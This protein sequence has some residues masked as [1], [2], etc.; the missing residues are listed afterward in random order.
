VIRPIQYLRGIAALMVVWHHCLHQLPGLYDLFPLDFTATG[1]DIF[2]VIS[3]FIM[4]VT[5]SGK[6]IS[7]REFFAHRVV[8]VVPL[9]WAATTLM[10]AL[11][12]LIP[13]Q[14]N[15]AQ[16]TA[17]TFVESLMFIPYDSPSF[18]GNPYPMLVPGWT[19]NYEMFFYAMFAASLAVPARSRL[20]GIALLFCQLAAIGHMFGP[21]VGAKFVYTDS[22]LLEFVAGM[23]I[24]TLWVKGK[25][26]EW[27]A[28]FGIAAIVGGFY[29]LMVGNSQMTLL[30]GASLIVLG[31]LTHSIRKI[32]LWPMMELGNASYSI[33]LT[34]LFTLGAM[35]D[36]W[37]HLPPSTVSSYAFMGVSLA[38][39][40]VAGWACYWMVERPMTARL[41][42]VVK[43]RIRREVAASS[44]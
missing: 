11:Y 31:S 25:V 37:K 6:D 43:R 4:V 41:Q 5:T 39:C 18:P 38:A 27:P 42:G 12:L 34:H 23:V 33:Y 24:G 19:L 28:A 2:F 8:R 44:A 13:S 10:A 17:R 30:A 36:V 3:G 40:A 22:R 1:V 14:F 9:Y 35:R 29:C 21:F 20:I 16:L 15:S 26:G 7:P 32:E